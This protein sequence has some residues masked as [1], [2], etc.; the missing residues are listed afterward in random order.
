VTLGHER[1]DEFGSVNDFA[2]GRES[3]LLNGR[4]SRRCGNA[5]VSHFIA[6]DATLGIGA[7]HPPVGHLLDEYAGDGNVELCQTKVAAMIGMTTL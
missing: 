1:P 4:R 3:S 7:V 5:L 2:H 6:Y